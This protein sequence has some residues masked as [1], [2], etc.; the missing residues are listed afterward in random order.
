MT[1]S[2]RFRQVDVARAI[3]A[4]KASGLTVTSV[5]IDVAGKIVVNCSGALPA[6]APEPNPGAAAYVRW[7]E[8]QGK[9]AAG[10]TRS[11]SV[12]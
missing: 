8:K 1:R 6:S 3:R 11:Q 12:N 4:A 9:K 5:E 7:K 2:L 10:K